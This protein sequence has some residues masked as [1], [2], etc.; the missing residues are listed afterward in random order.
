MTSDKEQT[1]GMT[2]R[3][4]MIV[5]I[6]FLVIIVVLWQVVGLFRGKSSTPAP[7]VA[8]NQTM[9]PAMRANAPGA[10][11][12]EA[13]PQPADVQKPVLSPREIALAQ[14]Q[15]ETQAKY[16]AALNE[17]QM[18]KISR[19]I[20]ETNRAI[21][22]AKLATITAEKNTLT[23]L[24][25]QPVAPGSYAKGLLNPTATGPQAQRPV[26]ATEVSYSVVSVS[27]LQYKWSAVLGYGGSLYSVSIGDVLPPDGST[28][29]SI[30]RSGV[31]LSKDGVTKK[32]SLVPVI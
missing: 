24:T 3:Q 25:N 18:L 14:L 31:V 22:I 30:N 28:V 17:L 1:A 16:L 19:E 9:T 23:L 12:K 5:G 27:Q 13:V 21:A 32:V 15:E 8:T 10:G 20:A 26:V 11:P 4:K 7:V 6:L 2:P 29:V